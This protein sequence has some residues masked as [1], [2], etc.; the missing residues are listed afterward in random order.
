MPT[1]GSK[2]R[3]Y[4]V[5]RQVDYPFCT[6]ATKATPFEYQGYSKA[7][8]SGYS[9]IRA[10]AGFFIRQ[11]LLRHFL[12]STCYYF[13]TLVWKLLMTVMIMAPFS[14][15]LFNFVL[16][17]HVLNLPIFL[18]AGSFATVHH[19]RRMLNIVLCNHARSNNGGINCFH[20]DCNNSL[21]FEIVWWKGQPSTG[22]HQCL[23]FGCQLCESHDQCY[24]CLFVEFFSLLN[25][26]N[27]PAFLG[28][29]S[30]RETAKENFPAVLEEYFTGLIQAMTTQE[31]HQE[32][33]ECASR[34]MK[35]PHLQ[36]SFWH[37]KM[38]LRNYD[39]DMTFFFPEFLS[40][41]Q[42]YVTCARSMSNFAEYKPYVCLNM[43]Y[44]GLDIY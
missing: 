22:C 8:E 14:P 9:V 4:V 17:V 29:K 5:R 42:S 23:C 6:R 25:T 11:H 21:P 12:G 15:Q 24:H 41:S 33:G 38:L 37:C 31:M 34:P 3:V 44:L 2:V 30:T 20:A 36:T 18:G 40:V 43:P 19:W 13:R 35:L 10:G 28:A 27:L 16:T 32:Q 7:T 1:V 26:Q 39:I